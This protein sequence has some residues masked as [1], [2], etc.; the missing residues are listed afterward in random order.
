MTIHNLFNLLLTKYIVTYCEYRLSNWVEAWSNSSGWF[1]ELTAGWLSVFL[2]LCVLWY[3]GLA[4]KDGLSFFKEIV[5]SV[6]VTTGY[7]THDVRATQRFGYY[8]QSPEPNLVCSDQ[9][10]NV[11]FIYSHWC[12]ICH[13]KL[14]CS[15]HKHSSLNQLGYLSI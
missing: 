13:G 12:E 6:F 1:C 4:I 10:V 8:C 3:V 2:F 7:W 5:L 14:G 11:A 15:S 9:L